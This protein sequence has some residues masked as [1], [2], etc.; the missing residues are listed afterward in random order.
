ML[1][2]KGQKTS[3]CVL[4]KRQNCLLRRIYMKKTD[5]YLFCFFMLICETAF[6]LC[7][8]LGLF[9]VDLLFLALTI[10]FYAS[11]ATLFGK[12]RYIFYII[13][14]ILYNIYFFAQDCYFSCFGTFF[15]I[16]NMSSL[17]ELSVVKGSILAF[18][19]PH[20]LIYLILIVIYFLLAIKY[21]SPSN[22][23]IK[24]A[25]QLLKTIL[26]VEFFMFAIGIFAPYLNGTQ[27]LGMLTRQGNLSYAYQTFL[28][29]TSVMKAYGPIAYIKRDV[30]LSLSKISSDLSEGDRTII[31]KY[32][33]W[34][35]HIDNEYTDTF[36]GKNLILIQAESLAPQAIDEDLTPNLYRMKQEGIYFSNFYAPL[37]PANTNDTEFTVQTGLLPSL[38]GKITAYAYPMNNYCV[39]LANLF[40][41]EG[42]SSDSYHTFTGDFY[43]RY[44]VHD[45]LGFDNFYDLRAIAPELVEKANGDYWIPDTTLFDYYLENQEKEPYYSFL[46]TTS[47]H[48]PYM[49]YVRPNLRQY[50]DKINEKY[51]EY[52]EEIKYYL[53]SQMELDEAIGKLID[54]LDNNT[55]VIIYGD[56]YPYGLKEENQDT[57]LE[58]GN[59]RYKVPLIIYGKDVESKQ[60]DKLCSSIDIFPTIGNMFG[61]DLNNSIIF[62]TDIMSDDPCTVYFKDG[63]ILTE[64]YYGIG[65]EEVYSISQTVLKTDYY[66]KQNN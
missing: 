6:R 21:E 36:K 58:E 38:S 25:R 26:S 64:D 19:K 10:C 34:S 66:N 41:N 42:Y 54:N 2:M 59:E 4:K 44:L 17:G 60:I 48:M 55:I 24:P 27:S 33:S 18:L 32:E 37:Y 9:W 43:N 45:G 16:Q 57:L 1:N 65:A 63:N 31:E 35:S 46:I 28:D 39:S 29:K 52:S 50:R 20:Q 5:F 11:V 8:G 49:E 22:L 56:H 15:S 61:L 13:I 51:L 12:K 30:E 14:I 62:G 23:K 40:K 7:T 47:G 53:A 3:F